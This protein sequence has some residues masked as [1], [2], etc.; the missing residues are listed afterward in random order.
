MSVVALVFSAYVF[1]DGRKRDRRDIFIK[2]HE[3]LISDSIQRGRYLLFE[4]VVDIDSVKFPTDEEYREI[5]QAIAAYNLLGVYLKNGYVN[6]RDVVDV[7]GPPVYR[8]W[9]SAQPFLAFREYN[10]GYK[11]MPFFELLAKR[12]GCLANYAADH[13]GSAGQESARPR[14]YAR[15][16]LR[17][18]WPV[19]VR[20]CHGRM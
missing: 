14:D 16:G 19:A 6:E 11:A 3:L 5:N 4:K 10:Q 2:M 12:V 13:Y 7:W 8:A 1:V 17:D 9:I 18:A 15:P 20:S